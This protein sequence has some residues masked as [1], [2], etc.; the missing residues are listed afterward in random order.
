MR[1]KIKRYNLTKNNGGALLFV[2][3]TA[4]VI[5]AISV[6]IV[7]VMLNHSMIMT[8]E[9]ERKEAQFLTR[10]AFAYTYDCLYDGT[11]PAGWFDTEIDFPLDNDVKIW[12]D[13]T[14]P[15]PGIPSNYRVSVYTN[16]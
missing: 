8:R 3:I 9:R 10:A 14:N 1:V 5:S 2:I 7:T 16:Y 6:I 4:L 12:I 13:S 15:D 11:W